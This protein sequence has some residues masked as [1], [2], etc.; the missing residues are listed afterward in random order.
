[1]RSWPPDQVCRHSSGAAE[2]AVCS[3]ASADV[4]TAGAGSRSKLS[5]ALPRQ[6]HQAS[7]A[8][9]A[10]QG[11]CVLL[12]LSWCL[13]AHDHALHSQHPA[14]DPRCNAVSACAALSGDLRRT[15]GLGEGSMWCM[16]ISNGDMQF[17]VASLTS[18][19]LI[20]LLHPAVVNLLG[21]SP[22]LHSRNAGHGRG[23][24]LLAWHLS[25]VQALFR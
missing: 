12:Q 16:L 23:L 10:A 13:P 8:A 21:G 6:A 15:P 1:M 22:V 4:A 5:A 3:A 25:A 20:L 19:W 7:S 2:V 24:S 14:D 11:A 18:S 17:L 9:H